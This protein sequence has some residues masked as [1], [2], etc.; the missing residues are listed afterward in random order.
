MLNCKTNIEIVACTNSGQRYH[1]AHT[2]VMLKKM[3]N[4]WKCQL[5]GAVRDILGQILPKLQNFALKL[6]RTNYTLS[7]C[8]GC[9]EGID[10]GRCISK[11]QDGRHTD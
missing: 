7:I 6:Y 3:S 1:C 10:Q 4:V 2:T 5:V 9:Q 11:I 8:D